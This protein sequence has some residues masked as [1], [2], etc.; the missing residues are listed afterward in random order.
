MS[1][2]SGKE[3]VVSSALQIVKTSDFTK[4]ETANSPL[5]EFPKNMIHLKDTIEQLHSAKNFSEPICPL[6]FIAPLLNNQNS[7]ANRV[8]CMVRT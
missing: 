4:I 3:I 7:A 6:F 8:H 5:S 2:Q 1:R